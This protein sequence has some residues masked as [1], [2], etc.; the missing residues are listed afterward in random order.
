MRKTLIF[1]CRSYDVHVG[2]FSHVA[3]DS[4]QVFICDHR[5]HWPVPLS[6]LE[7]IQPVFYLSAFGQCQQRPVT[8]SPWSKLLASA[9]HGNNGLPCSVLT[10]K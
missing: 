7:P 6:E 5:G 3:K 8:Q 4:L 10:C 2:R 1:H 9:Y